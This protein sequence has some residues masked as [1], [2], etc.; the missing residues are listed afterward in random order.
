VKGQKHTRK[1][2]KEK[3]RKNQETTFH[4]I[5]QATSTGCVRETGDYNISN[6]VL[7]KVKL[8]L[9]LTNHHAMKTYWG[10]GGI[11]ARILDLGTRWR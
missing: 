6:I 3:K 11:A 2:D 7:V 1:Q 4:S 8:S 5:L 10:S 9:C